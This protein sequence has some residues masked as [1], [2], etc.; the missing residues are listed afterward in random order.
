MLRVQIRYREARLHVCLFLHD[1][2][3]GEHTTIVERS[4]L[5]KIGNQ[6]RRI[7]GL[8]WQHA[9][10]ND[11]DQATLHQLGEKLSRLLVADAQ[12]PIL[13]QHVGQPLML[14]L[15]PEG[16]S[17]PWELAVLNDRTWNSSFALGRSVAETGWTKSA[18][19]HRRSA[20]SCEFRIFAN[21]TFDLLHAEDEASGVAKAL[22]HVS[23]VVPHSY[24][25]EPTLAAL[26][27]ELSSADGFHFAGHAKQGDVGRVWPLRDGNLTPADVRA[28]RMVVPQFIFAHACGSANVDVAASED[29]LVMA[30]LESG[31][32]HF[33]GLWTPFLDHQAAEFAEVF[34]TLF[35][36]AAPLGQTL[37][38]TRQK[39]RDHFGWSELSLG[40]YVLYGDPTAGLLGTVTDTESRHPALG[41]QS[42]VASKTNVPPLSYPVPCATCGR[43]LKSRFLVGSVSVVG[44]HVQ[45]R[46]KYCETHDHT[47]LTRTYA[48]HGEEPAQR[49]ETPA[50]T[51]PGREPLP[52]G[53]ARLVQALQTPTSLVDPETDLRF[54]A[55]W[56]MTN[57]QYAAVDYR[58]EDRKTDVA[59]PPPKWQLRLRFLPLAGLDFDAVAAAITAG[60]PSVDPRNAAD[61]VIVVFVTTGSILATLDPPQIELLAA[62]LA[63]HPKFSCLG[64]DLESESALPIK[65]TA[66]SRELLKC[67]HWQPDDTKIRRAVRQIDQLRPLEVS[68]SA[69]AIAERLLIPLETV[70]V[71]CRILSQQHDTL[72]FDEVPPFGW[73]LS[74]SA[75]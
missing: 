73:V 45:V 46:C 14:D 64:I 15:C 37:W 25:G 41:V 69:A 72:H 53:W 10:G 74:E 18:R 36:P 35:S 38:Q 13:A 7:L 62:A 9:G 31:T 24:V 55:V 65:A 75:H 42:H 12:L 29:N 4:E 61:H 67:L 27:R 26:L 16:L 44:S 63:G 71:A 50:T 48:V 32:T 21:P 20:S 59:L 11:H 6:L 5:L 43:Q 23:G 70:M 57:S 51:P 19:S 58:L 60:L 22:A 34:Y 17:V 39:L 2:P 40:N 28:A 30:F 56:Q 66:V 68:L 54:D 1:K 47:A 33:L 52:A 3:I 49:V 8:G